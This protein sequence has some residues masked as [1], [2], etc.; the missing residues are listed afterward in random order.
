MDQVDQIDRIEPNWIEMD[1]IDQIEPNW[2]EMD[3]N[4]TLMWLNINIAT[5]NTTLKTFR[6]YIYFRKQKYYITIYH[7][8]RSH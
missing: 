4:A 5:I 3:Q 1:Q 6:Y 2:I 7:R 8:L